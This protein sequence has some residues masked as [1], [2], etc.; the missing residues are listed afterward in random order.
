MI[1]SM[2]LNLIK[3][4]L[5]HSKTFSGIETSQFSVRFSHLLYIVHNIENFFFFTHFWV[6]YHFK[7]SLFCLMWIECIELKIAPI[8]HPAKC[9]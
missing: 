3:L 2:A 9:I 5:R 8:S 1:F 6:N 7:T 4:N